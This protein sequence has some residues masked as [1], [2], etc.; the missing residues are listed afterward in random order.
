[1]NLESIKMTILA[2]NNPLDGFESE[3]GFSL[4]IETNDTR[5]LF[6]TGQRDAM[7]NNANK[8]G[9][10]LHR[11]NF[12]VLSHGHYDHTGGL[13]S[14][15]ELAPAVHVFCHPGVGRS[16][17][18]VRKENVKSIGM[19]AASKTALEKLPPDRI[20][21]MTQPVEISRGIGI[22]GKIPRT[23]DYETTGGP[24][25]FDESG[26]LADPIEDDMAMWM[27][28]EKGLVIVFG[29]G[30]A[31]LINTLS[32]IEQITSPTKIH[33]LIGGFHLVEASRERIDRTIAA[34]LD[35]NLDL[36]IPCHC[37]G[38]ASIQKLTEKF[39]NRVV[40]GEAGNT[41]TVG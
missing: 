9:V 35:M 21:E 5:I 6:D 20:H 8:L 14:I 30:H 33:T 12:L 4:W 32:Y 26:T 23:N 11:A 28:T 29:C 17:Y 27:H 38:N 24:F 18:S 34:L 7:L 10:P 1:M 22:T 31:G 19:S 13:P 41:Y 39:G 3:H 15:I 25:F 2:D 37:T 36:I 40:I 16:R